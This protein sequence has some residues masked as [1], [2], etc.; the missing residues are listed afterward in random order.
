MFTL[1]DLLEF[2][3]SLMFITA[4]PTYIALL[5]LQAPYAKFSTSTTHPYWGPLIPAKWAWVIQESPSLI[6]SLTTFLTYS[7]PVTLHSSGNVFL[8]SLYLFHYFFRV[9]VFPF[10]MRGAK[11]CPLSVMLLS[12]LFCFIN[13]SMQGYALSQLPPTPLSSFTP[14]QLVGVLIFFIGF[15]VNQHADHT[16]RSLRHTPNDRA[17]YIPHGGLFHWVTAANYCGELIEWVGWSLA[18]HTW[19]SVAFAVYTFANLGPRAQAYQ[20]WY[21]DKFDN[22][23]KHRKAMI[24]YIY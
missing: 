20:R 7:K 14:T 22:Y 18:C 9:L 12:T 24:P 11:P 5:Y 21:H 17:H 19:A 15:T 2:F 6:L 3:P 23:P 16:L 4:I 1:R 8:L 13:G 10:L